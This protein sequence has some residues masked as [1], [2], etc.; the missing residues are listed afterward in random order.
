MYPYLWHLWQCLDLVECRPIR[1]GFIWWLQSSWVWAC[2]ALIWL[3]L[4]MGKTYGMCIGVNAGVHAD[5]GRLSAIALD[6]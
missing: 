5:A 4:G 2:K 6:I 1:V 3:V